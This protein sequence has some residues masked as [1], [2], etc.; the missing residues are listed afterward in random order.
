MT[1]LESFEYK[2]TKEGHG[3]AHGTRGRAAARKDREAV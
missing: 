3:K 2:E 1:P